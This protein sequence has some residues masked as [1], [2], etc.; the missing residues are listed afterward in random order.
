MVK[1]R[2]LPSGSWNIRIKH[3]GK[4]RSFTAETREEVE[5]QAAAYL[6]KNNKL[7]SGIT[8]GMAIDRYI[9]LSPTLSPTTLQ[10]YRKIKQYAFQGMMD[11]DV[12]ELTDPIAQ[13]FINQEA[14]RS[15][16]MVHLYPR[17]Q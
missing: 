17:R 7:K 16:R 4:Y 9:E 5:K 15:T 6:L 14:R 11:C 10:A 13:D 12:E 3:D 2:Q 1:A 8:V